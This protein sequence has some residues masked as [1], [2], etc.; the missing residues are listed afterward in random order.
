MLKLLTSIMM[1]DTIRKPYPF[2]V[3]FHRLEI[4]SIMGNRQVTI[5]NLQHLSDAEIV[6]SEL[7]KCDIPSK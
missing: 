7:I 5:N 6:F 4:I 2:Q 3:Q 1:I